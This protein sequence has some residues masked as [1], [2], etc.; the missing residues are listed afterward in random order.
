MAIIKPNQ[1][2]KFNLTTEP[3]TTDVADYVQLVDNTDDTQFQLGLTLCNGQE[4]VVP[5]PNFED[6]ADYG[7]SSNWT[8]SYVGGNGQICSEGTLANG[9]SSVYSFD[10]TLYYY[11]EINVLSCTDGSVF[12]VYLG[13]NLIGTFSEAGVFSAYGFPTI[14]AA[15][16]LLSVQQRNAVDVCC[17]SSINAYPLLTNFII[18]IYNTADVYVTS[19][20]YAS[21]P[22]Y[23]AFVEDSVTITIDW[24]TLG[25]SDNCYYL[26]L[27]DPCENTN[28]QN[29]P[30]VITNNTFTGSATGWTLGASWSYAANAV[31]ATYSAALPVSR[32]Y[33]TSSDV[34]VN[35][36]STYDVSV[37]VTAITGTI[38]VYFGG[39]LVETITTTGVHVCTGT[40]NTNLDFYIYIRSGT[41]TVTSCVPS[42]VSSANY[43]TNAETNVFQLSDYINICP[44]T[45]LINA[46]NSS[47][48]FGFVFKNAGF[49]PRIRL[50]SKLKNSNYDNERVKSEDSSGKVNIAY[51]KRRKTKLFAADLLPEYIHDFLS[52]LS[53]YDKFY[54]D[55]TAYIV[56]DDEYNVTYDA[57]QDNVG[58]I[59]MRVSEQVQL[60]RNVNC[61]GDEIS[62]VL[63][64]N[65]L[66]N[67][68]YLDQYITLENGELIIING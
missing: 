68:S 45:L 62:C 7:Y 49:T 38:E 66:L 18:P 31:N 61:N 17:I 52:T 65:Y 25:L 19:I 8:I 20:S 28:G 40:P 67:D 37:N 23:F 50:L 47:N 35:Y 55:D 3:C 22:T 6:A 26:G 4:N 5:S 48:A 21:N 1:P 24:S 44:N 2:V 51:F 32:N 29:Y 39:V 13:A 36:I 10:P 56:E 58:S 46:C 33:L 57:S 63:G 30:P 41:V 11:V 42:T 9:F 53:G 64:V 54:I 15:Q 43:T 27:L 59:E 34:F 12:D 14:Q 60:V 16:Y